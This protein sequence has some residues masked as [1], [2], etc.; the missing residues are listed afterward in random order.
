MML[1]IQWHSE[2]TIWV[3]NRFTS[4]PGCH[5]LSLGLCL[6]MLKK[7]Q[8]MWSHPAYCSEFWSPMLLHFRNTNVIWH[9]FWSSYI[10]LKNIKQLYKWAASKLF[11][12][13]FVIITSAVSLQ[14]VC[15]S[16]VSWETGITDHVMLCFH[17]MKFCKVNFSW[18]GLSSPLTVIFSNSNL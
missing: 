13:F 2:S 18:G 15:V 3:A 17:S 5:F 10:C 16:F 8:N 14:V 1:W 6:C 12:V 9:Y 4:Q 11:I 7:K